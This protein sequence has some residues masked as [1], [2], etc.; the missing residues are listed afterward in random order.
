MRLAKEIKI[1]LLAVVAVVCLFF[2][3]RF[4]RGTDF[5]ASNRTFYAYYDDIGGLEASN[6]VVLNGMSVGIVQK[7][8]LLKEQNYKIRVTLD[9]DKEVAIGDGTVASLISSSLLGG[10]AIELIMQPNTQLYQG[11]ETLKTAASAD[12][13]EQLSAQAKP[14]MADLDSTIRKL[15]TFLSPASQ[16]SL[17]KTL[18]NMEATTAALNQLVLANQRNINQITG[19]AS[20]LTNSLIGTERELH[21][22]A[23]S[24]NAIADTFKRA[25]INQTIH[26][27]NLAMMDLRATM[28]KIESPN[29]TLGMLINDKA[30]YYN[31]AQSSADL[32]R[33]LVDVRLN[34]KR[35]VN[36]SL[37]GRKNKSG[38]VVVDVMK[39]GQALP[40]GTP[41]PAAAAD[42]LPL[43]NP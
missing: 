28:K 1:A 34:P 16:H 6:S 22:L 25:E 43:K 18:A 12:L 2:G 4:L 10:K 3:Y 13:T 5:F 33:L 36:F 19:N 24:L 31:L 41:A 40:A 29:G 42:T 15:N 37:I 23:G 17:E 26:N 11:G 32:D 7:L 38:D 35:Y 21:R 14:L 8:E 9:I 39:P 27:A 20:R 30:M